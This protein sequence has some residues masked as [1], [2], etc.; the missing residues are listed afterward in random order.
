MMTIRMVL[1]NTVAVIC[2][3]RFVENTLVVVHHG[4]TKKPTKI[5]LNA[6]VQTGE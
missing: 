5:T 3:T 6:T 1:S 2:V 4:F